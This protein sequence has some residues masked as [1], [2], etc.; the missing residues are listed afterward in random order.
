MTVA[1]QILQ[2]KTD[3]DDVYAKGVED[4]KAQGGNTEEAY[5]EGYTAGQKSEYDTFWD[6]FQNYGKRTNYSSAFFVGDAYNE[7]GWTESTFK[8]K[9]DIKPVGSINQ[10]L[11]GVYITDMVEHLKSLNVELD[12]SK[13]TNFE[14]CFSYSTITHL[15]VIDFSS[16]TVSMSRTFQGCSLLQTIDKIILSEAT[17]QKGFLYAFDSC[18]ALREISSIEGVINQ[19]IDVAIAP[20]NIET[21]RRI[22]SALKDYS[23]TSV[24]Y[25]CCLGATNLAKLTDEEK[26]IATEKGWTLA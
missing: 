21:I 11:R 23:G 16:A 14:Y 19:S 15:G 26:A 8:P 12:L 4:G 18:T 25:T 22:I 3:L 13:A 5:Q 2:A 1:E 24:V 9:Y 17:N 6:S 20:L 7:N 10:M